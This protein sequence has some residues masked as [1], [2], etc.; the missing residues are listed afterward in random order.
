MKARGI[1]AVIPMK[2]LHLAKSRLA[3][4]LDTEKRERLTLNLLERVVL[5]ALQS[6]VCDVWIVGGG[7]AVERR[8]LDLGVKWYDDHGSDLN[9]ALWTYFQRAFASD[10]AALYI[11]TDLPFLTSQ[12]IADVV[13]TSADGQTLTL[14]P[15]HR[16]GGTN[17]II[18]PLWSPLRPALGPDSFQL[19]N[20]QAKLL[21]LP[22]HICD[23][24]GLRLDLDTVADLQDFE[25]IE[26]GLSDRLTEG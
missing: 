26:P 5:A 11:P 17:A 22:V 8:A 21:G 2:S 1:V 19:H 12:D 14:S 10:L 24:Q 15:A 7:G 18:D 13:A 3:E 9:G 20:D 4:R 23:R 6:P 25:K 16:D